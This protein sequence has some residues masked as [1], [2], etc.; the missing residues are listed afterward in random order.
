MN[1]GV[2]LPERVYLDYAGF[3]PVDPRVLAVMRPFLEAGIGNPAVPHSLG[4]E[5][6]VALEAARVKVA[7]LCGGPASG[8]VFTSG[9][10]EANNLAI[11]GVAHG[12][13][14][15]AEARI[16]IS[17]VEHISVINACR[18]LE[19][20]GATVVSIP[21]DAE[22][23]VEL[24][25]LRRALATPT[26][27]VS[28]GAASHEIGTLQPLAEIGRLSRAA[29]VPLHV[30]AVGAI[31]RVSLGAE[32]MG[33]DLVTLSSNDIY[34]PPGAGALWV[35]GQM[36]LCPQM[37]GGGQEDGRRSGT[38]NLPAIVGFGVAADLMR[39]ESA[40]GE[41]ARLAAL[42]D[43]LV[44]GVLEA[45][46]DCRLTGARAARLPHHASFVARGV[47]ADAVLL[48]LDLA[49]I[50]ASSSSA[51]TSLTRTP[52]ATLRAIGC[53]ADEIEGSL[54]FTLGRWSTPADVDAVVTSLPPI[55]SRLRAPAP[56]APR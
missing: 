47:K 15:P 49:H 8:V 31:G 20:A 37:V 28:V 7:R 42:R 32:A 40:H 36:A 55:V 34:G 5:A 24:D 3:A 1:L 13:R 29:G 18:D 39:I 53:P 11:K 44:D 4:A 23:R 50:A 14:T 45:M 19:R 26:T 22:G 46:G 35:R 48:A 16:V 21:V 54:C 51:C 56:V 2:D 6:R 41:P 9:A 33:I 43:R 30:D 25:K 38:E 52:S 12:A 27:L 17:A 10:T